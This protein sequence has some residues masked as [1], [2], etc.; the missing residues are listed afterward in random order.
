[1]PKWLIPWL[2]P[3]ILVIAVII[4]I[5]GGIPG[6]IA[7]FVVVF[8]FAGWLRVQQLHA[9]GGDDDGSYT[10]LSDLV[11]WVSDLRRPRR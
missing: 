10:R 11:P 6:L 8:A 1:M 7:A 3:L 4:G 5:V 2:V 9:R